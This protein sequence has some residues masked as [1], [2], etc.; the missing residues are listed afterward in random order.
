MKRKHKKTPDK[1][2]EVRV[3]A[4]EAVEDSVVVRLAKLEKWVEELENRVYT[5]EE[6]T[7]R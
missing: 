1:T 3:D 6:T 7:V 4:G 5:L 2:L